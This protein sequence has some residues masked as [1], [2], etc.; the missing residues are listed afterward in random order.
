MKNILTI[1]F[2]LFTFLS[3]SQTKDYKPAYELSKKLNTEYKLKITS[4]DSVILKQDLYISDLNNIIL[5]NNKLSSQD[6]LHIS[7]LVQQKD[8]LNKNINLYKKELDR[9]DKFWNKPAFGIILGVA[10]T[11]GL[12]HVIDYTLP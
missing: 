5:V 8:F 12:I 3:Y 10:G 9:R 7:L 2:L 4:L 6:S 1:I 11:V